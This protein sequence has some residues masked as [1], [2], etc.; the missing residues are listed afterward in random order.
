M[1]EVQR[2]LVQAVTATGLEPNQLSWNTVQAHSLRGACTVDAEDY[3]YSGLVSLGEAIRGLQQNRFT[4]STV[5]AYY[6]TFYL[7]RCALGRG[8]QS[9]EFYQGRRKRHYALR[10]MAGTTPIVVSGNTHDAVLKHAEAEN[11][12]RV[13]AGQP[14]GGFSTAWQW[15][16]HQRNQAN[17]STTRFPDP[18]PTPSMRMAATIGTRQAMLTYLS[19]QSLTYTFDDAHAML[20]YPATLAR[21]LSKPSG[22]TVESGKLTHLDTLFADKDGPFAFA[23]FLYRA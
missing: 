10:A 15:L 6:A 4:W 11:I 16:M 8:G 14:I 13:L 21:L 19:D 23:K 9:V 17:Y 3:W 5:K 22:A 12:F 18:E 2:V 7:S 20:A 1:G